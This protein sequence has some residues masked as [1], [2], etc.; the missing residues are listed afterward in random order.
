MEDRLLASELV[1]QPGIG[2]ETL[3]LIVVERRT[4]QLIGAGLGG[5]ADVAATGAAVFGLEGG[6]VDPKLFDGID[7]RREPVHIADV[8]AP[9][10]LD[11]HAVDADVEVM[12]LAAA[13]LQVIPGAFAIA[14]FDLRHHHHDRE[15]VAHPAADAGDRKRHVVHQLVF[16]RSGDFGGFGLQRRRFAG[17]LNALGGLADLEHD[18]DPDVV[19]TAST[20][21]ERENDLK[22][23]NDTDTT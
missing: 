12:L 7:R 11:G 6:R 14:A 9:A 3:G 8:V 13:D 15:G 18:I 17:H 5:D 1:V 21:P 16:H 20:M 22:P 4:V 23:V 2:V 19:V 10:H